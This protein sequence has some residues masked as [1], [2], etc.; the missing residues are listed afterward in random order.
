MFSEPIAVK[1]GLMFEN[2]LAGC[3]VTESK[4][5]RITQHLEFHT[6]L[7]RP[8]VNHIRRVDTIKSCS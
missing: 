5:S 1:V 6:A 4:C 3:S 8:I 7:R 2:V